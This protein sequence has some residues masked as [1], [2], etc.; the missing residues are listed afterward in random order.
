MVRSRRSGLSSP[1]VVF[2]RKMK[3]RSCHLSN[4]R[5][6]GSSPERDPGVRKGGHEVCGGKTARGCRYDV[7]HVRTQRLEVI[8]KSTPPCA[9]LPHQSPGGVAAKFL[10]HRPLV[11]GNQDLENFNVSM[12]NN[13]PST[14][15]RIRQARAIP[16]STVGGP[17][18]NSA[19]SFSANFALARVFCER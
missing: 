2:G 19:F 10:Q 16:A 8:R 11:E 14:S 4:S 9:N 3:S 5:S 17:V 12:L 1:S 7:C 13:R 15:N 18:S 6:V